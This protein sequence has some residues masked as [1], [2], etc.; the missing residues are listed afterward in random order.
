MGKGDAEH[1]E[2][3]QNRAPEVREYEVCYMK[4][5]NNTRKKNEKNFQYTFYTLFQTGHGD[6]RSNAV[7][8]VSPLRS[9]HLQTYE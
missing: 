7:Y 8:D 1:R 2:V 5:V 6:T 4:S 3:S 9:Q